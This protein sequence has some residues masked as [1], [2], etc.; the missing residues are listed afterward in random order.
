[1][2]IATDVSRI[3]GNITAA[4]AAIAD[5]GVTVPDGSTS[6][7]LAELIASIEAGG[8]KIGNFSTFNYGSFQ[9]AEDVSDYT[10]DLGYKGSGKAPVVEQFF[11][12]RDMISTYSGTSTTNSLVIAAYL[13]NVSSSSISI[14]S[15]A[16]T[17][18]YNSSGSISTST[19]AVCEFN[20]ITS[21][22]TPRT[23]TVHAAKANSSCVLTSGATYNWIVLR[24]EK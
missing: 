19:G 9:L 21:S 16:A 24:R 12:L 22:S 13:S 23:M 7:A 11:L 6:D 10:I 20:S 18:Y 17:R 3:K 2:S 4:L 14:S 15:V 1:M 8:I 5:K